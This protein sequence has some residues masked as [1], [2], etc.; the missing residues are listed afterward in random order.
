MKLH[1]IVAPR[2]DL[3]F[4]IEEEYTDIKSGISVYDL[5]SELAQTPNL[6]EK[7][8]TV[9]VD[10]AVVPFGEWKKYFLSEEKNHEIKFILEPEGTFVMLAFVFIAMVAT[11]LYTMRMMNKLNSHT[12]VDKSG[13]SRS[14]Y[15]VNAQGNK[16]KLG[17]VIPEQFGLFKKFPD[18]LADAHSFYRDNEY[19]L[20]LILSQ[21]IGYFQHDL[22]NI[23][24]GATPLSVLQGI[25]CQVCD[26][27]A[28]LSQNS[29]APEITKCWYNSTEVTS[30]GH[31]LHALTST[32][33]EAN[34][35]LEYQSIFVEGYDLSKFRVGDLVKISGA[36]NEWV[37]LPAFQDTAEH[38]P[39]QLSSDWEV[40]ARN[41]YRNNFDHVHQFAVYPFRPKEM[42]EA[43]AQSASPRHTF[44]HIYVKQRDLY[45]TGSTTASYRLLDI[46]LSECSVVESARRWGGDEWELNS[47]V[48]YQSENAW[49]PSTD[50][51]NYMLLGNNCRHEYYTTGRW[52]P[53]TE[54]SIFDYWK[55]YYSYSGGPITYGTV[56]LQTIPDN[57]RIDCY[58]PFGMNADTGTSGSVSYQ[59]RYGSLY[60]ATPTIIFGS[61]PLSYEIKINS[62]GT[63]KLWNSRLKT[64]AKFKVQIA[65]CVRAKVTE[66][67]RKDLIGKT[68]DIIANKPLKFA[69]PL[70]GTNY[71]MGSAYSTQ[72]VYCDSL[73]FKL[74]Y[75]DAAQHIES[76]FL[77]ED[78]FG[79]LVPTKVDSS[80]GWETDPSYGIEET[81]SDWKF[82][83]TDGTQTYKA[84][85]LCIDH[86]H[87]GTTG[88][89][90]HNCVAVRVTA[91]PEGIWDFYD[92]RRGTVDDNGFY[93]VVAVYGENSFSAD[94]DSPILVNSKSNLS[95]DNAKRLFTT[96][97]Q[98]HRVYNDDIIKASKDYKGREF[99]SLDQ[100]FKQT[101][102]GGKWEDA[103]CYA[104][105]VTKVMLHRCDSNGN[106]YLD[107]TGFWAVDSI[108]KNAVVEN[109]T[110]GFSTRDVNNS[111]CGPYRAAPIGVDVSEI[112]V[113]LYAPGGIY[114]R[115]DQG[116][117][118]PYNVTVRIEY[119]K[120]G[121]L[122]WQHRDVTLTSNGI[123]K[124]VNGEYTSTGMDA[125]GV[126]EKFDLPKGDWYFRCYRLTEEHSDDTTHYSDVVKWTGLKSVIANPQSYD[127]ITVLLMRFKGSE[128]LSELSDNQISTLFTRMLPNIETNVLEPTSA[129]AP[130]VKYICDRSKFASLL[131]IDNIVDMDA[132]WNVRGLDLN[133]TL[134]SDNTLLNVLSDILHIGYSE[135]STRA[136]GLQIVQIGE[137]PNVNYDS[138]R[139]GTPTSGPTDFSFIF[140]PQN[141]SNLKIDVALPR[142]DDAEEIEV[143]YTDVETYKTATVYVHMSSS[144]YSTI[145]VTDYPTSIYQEKLQ[146]F[147]VTERAQAVAMGARRLRSI[148]RN[149][150]KFSLTTEFD[151][152]NC[153]YKDFV[154]LVV[155]E[156]TCGMLTAEMRH[157][158]NPSY[159]NEYIIQ[160]SISMKDGYSGRVTNYSNGIIE[161]NPPLTAEQYGRGDVSHRPTA[162]FITDEEGQPHLLSIAY[163]DWI[164]AKSFR[165]T[166]PVTWYGTD[167]ELPRIVSAVII[168]CW[169]EKI[170]PSE[171]NCTIELTMYDSSIF[172]DD[173][174]MREGY[175]VSAY[176]T[177][178]Y[179]KSY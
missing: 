137:H 65:Y 176:G 138:G 87:A 178:P 45:I 70:I 46:P 101:K 110:Q 128:T 150:I 173:L 64:N 88:A 146:L 31:T 145:E 66:C 39:E 174:P 60:Q 94:L 68:V 121:E 23:Y 18:Y 43:D 32:N 63:Y 41:N 119:K 72:W 102:I 14:I 30:S 69:M 168:P 159:G 134:D 13:E 153:N 49:Y 25:Q 129:L 11:F 115:N 58:S 7:S 107:W 16:I 169:V 100:Y 21:G 6:T 141:Y 15:D 109:I 40:R 116:D 136:D 89:L 125:V 76:A 164:N 91:T 4:I 85:Y 103:P 127:D 140:S 84:N 59:G 113:D 96:P 133:G 77:Y 120:A 24:V 108:Q 104:P 52:I 155:D 44:F 10:G 139:W 2:H 42:K 86:E 20:D 28:D 118:E 154:G 144:Q 8:I 38:Y 36:N 170:K 105:S 114:R 152:L 34:V 75:V 71:H 131:H 97:H 81:D 143:Q 57:C 80:M 12:G 74:P 98:N 179:G 175:G 83:I 67:H 156:P 54:Y 161:I 172:T 162:F 111:M 158:H 157:S 19:Y 160:D 171:K 79:S 1:L 93:K 47:S 106:L 56:D 35:H 48:F 126:T 90:G 151:S 163:N 53:I 95:S 5:V 112:E 33:T 132:I 55:Q 37:V 147:G 167:I 22:S 149:R 117:V 82:V 29:I 26:P 177:S 3:D 124:F 27:S 50:F 142:R 165:A 166:L 135:L 78:F 148:L 122:Q 130:A 99:A 9:I 61:T 62:N 123:K 17:D 92:R 73:C 51:D